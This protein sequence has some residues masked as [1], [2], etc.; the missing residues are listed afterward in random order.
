MEELDLGWAVQEQAHTNFTTTTM[1]SNAT[2]ATVDRAT[3]EDT[4]TAGT[5]PTS[6]NA[7]TVHIDLQAA[8][9][10]DDVNEM[11]ITEASSSGQSQPEETD[12]FASLKM[13]PSEIFQDCSYDIIIIN[14]VV[15]ADAVMQAYDDAYADGSHCASTKD[16]QILN[17]TLMA[18]FGS[19][20]R[21]RRGMLT[22]QIAFTA[23]PQVY[24]Q[25]VFVVM[26]ASVYVTTGKKLALPK[27]DSENKIYHSGPRIVRPNI[28]GS[29]PE[30]SF[31]NCEEYAFPICNADKE[32]AQPFD[33]PIM[34]VTPPLPA[35]QGTRICTAENCIPRHTFRFAGVLHGVTTSLFWKPIFAAAH[36]AAKDLGVELDMEPFPTQPNRDVHYAKMGARIVHAC[37]SGVDG[38]IVTIPNEVLLDSIRI[39][40]MLNVPV[41][42]INSGAEFSEQLGLMV[43]IGQM[44]YNAGYEGGLRL[45]RE[46]MRE[47][48]CAIH[49]PGEKSLADR[50]RGFADAIATLDGVAYG[51]VVIVSCWR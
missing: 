48:Y 24:L 7:N 46:G 20:P 51:G 50:C 23:T 14:G 8:I 16:I 27:S 33:S 49:G 10:W 42:S 4:S 5:M 18:T 30:D 36:Q 44:E 38:I 9:L 39:C 1:Y 25:S 37:E 22:K 3:D 29:I 32:Y 17:S 47:G 6:R 41:V 11:T 34:A 15:T 43:H 13:L 2:N 31:V 12:M 19:S 26:M 40:Q 35:T 21:I 45:A 28:Y